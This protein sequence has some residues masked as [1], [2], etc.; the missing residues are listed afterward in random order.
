MRDRIASAGHRR[1]VHSGYDNQSRLA[2]AIA[3]SPVL[4]GHFSLRNQESPKSGSGDGH[5]PFG[6]ED[7]VM[8]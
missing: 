8:S 6:R 4:R 2:E 3:R 1:A 7:R 5:A